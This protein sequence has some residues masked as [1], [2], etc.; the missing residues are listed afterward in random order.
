M[1]AKVFKL[2][3]KI[4]L[5]LLVAL[6]TGAVGIFITTSAVLVITMAQT[7]EHVFK[8]KLI[9]SSHFL[10]NVYKSIYQKTNDEAAAFEFAT[11]TF[12]EGNYG[13]FLIVT[14]DDQKVM[15]TNI[16]DKDLLTYERIDQSNKYNELISIDFANKNYLKFTSS[17]TLHNDQKR[18]LEV[19]SHNHGLKDV[20]KVTI[21]KTILITWIILILIAPLFYYATKKI[22]YPVQALAGEIRQI[23]SKNPT[24]WKLLR[25]DKDNY[26]LN[27]IIDSFNEIIVQIQKSL[28]YHNNLAR[29]LSHEIKTPLTHLIN[30]LEMLYWDKKSSE[31]NASYE[32]AIQDILRIKSIVNNVSELTYVD[33]KKTPDEYLELNEVIQHLTTEFERIY[34]CKVICNLNKRK[35]VFVRFSPDYFWMLHSNILRNSLKHGKGNII[36]PVIQLDCEETKCHIRYTD[37]GPGFSHFLLE[38]IHSK[39]H[40]LSDFPGA[41]IALCLRLAEVMNFEISF[42]N[43]TP[44]GALVT[45]HIDLESNAPS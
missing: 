20:L 35:K 13:K 19:F 27:E 1:A 37:A 12:G 42:E 39:K 38:Q 9:N 11:K 31:I 44:N 34:D 8:E 25:Y 33:I 28:I 45:L 40:E 23:T 29:F 14:D 32:R 41:G 6:I 18:N 16:S 24:A 21:P 26:F 5:N 2:Q 17:F 15:F 22:L 36:S 3:N 30:E 4:F 10:I 43:N 7:S